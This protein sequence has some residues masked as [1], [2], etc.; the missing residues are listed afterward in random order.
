VKDSLPRYTLR[1]SRLLLGKLGYI[2]EYEGHSINKELES[3]IRYRVCDFEEQNGSIH[4][5]WWGGTYEC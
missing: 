3:M 5:C 4:P 1:V 2:A